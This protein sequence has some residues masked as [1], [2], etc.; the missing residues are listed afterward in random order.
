MYG[1]IEHPEDVWKECFRILK[2]GGRLLA[3]LDNGINYIVDENEMMIT[4][5]LPYN[6]LRNPDQMKTMNPDDGI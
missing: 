1:Y 5:S 6:P 3:G 4:S 2:C